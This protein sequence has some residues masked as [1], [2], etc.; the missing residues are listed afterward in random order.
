L[1]LDLDLDL[2]VDL[3]PRRRAAGSWTEQLLLVASKRTAWGPGRSP[4]PSPGL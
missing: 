3:D 4:R 2:D 1:D